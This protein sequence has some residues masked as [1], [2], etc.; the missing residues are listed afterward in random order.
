[1]VIVMVVAAARPATGHPVWHLVLP[2]VISGAVFAGLKV[3][4]GWQHHSPSIARPRLTRPEIRAWDRP[5]GP[6]V[7]LAVASGGAGVIHA[8]VC[9]AHFREAIAFGV[10]FLV[11]SAL[12]ATWAVLM[13]RRPGSALLTLGLVGNAAVVALW[14]VSRTVGVPVGPDAWRPE[15]ITAADS[16]ATMLELAIIVGIPWMIHRGRLDA[17]RLVSWS[18]LSGELPASCP[19]P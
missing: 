9:P 2:A 10:F 6:V 11:A 12:Q 16:L 5:S 7:A 15:A 4:E 18:K 13:L 19:S 8:S 1:M 3:W 14:A 17:D